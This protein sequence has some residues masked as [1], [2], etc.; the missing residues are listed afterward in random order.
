MTDSFARFSLAGRL[1]F[2][3]GASS[4]IGAHLA[5]CLADAGADIVLAARRIDKLN[6][7]RD[8]IEAKGRRAW[9]VQL[10][11]T[12]RDSV[13][14]AVDKTE[15]E[16][17]AID[18]LI[19]NAGLADTSSFLDMTEEAWRGVIETDLTGVWRVGQVVARKM[20]PRGRGSIIN[21]ASV[22]GLA[23]QKNQSNYASAKAGVAQLTR[24][25]ALELGRAG[26]RV[27]AVAP[28]YF[29]T[30]MNTDFFQTPGGRAYV[31]R[32]FPR[33]LGELSELDGPVLLLASDAGSFVNGIV[34]TVDGGTLLRG[35]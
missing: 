20:M 25:M 34:L 9:S 26:L 16:F 30:E 23:V 6:T 1:A 5:R 29:E 32:L 35:L 10:D 24:A 15:T 8:E 31:E 14:A 28:G 13:E 3:T 11:V 21:L 33:R 4:G 18:I 17:G 19:N 2:I 22:L 12:D 27:N 7:L